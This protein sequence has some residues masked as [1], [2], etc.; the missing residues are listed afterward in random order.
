MIT[1]IWG[2]YYIDRWLDLC[3]AALRSEG[4]I[5]YMIEHCDFELAIVT[6][7]AD[8]E[9]MQASPKFNKIMAGIRIRFVP[10]DEF[11]P[12]QGTISYG[13]PLTL[14]YAKAILDL[15]DAA[16]GTYVILMNADLL[17]ASGSLKSMVAHMRAGDDIITG[18]S[19]RVIDG[20]PRTVL[21]AQIDRETGILSMG[22]RAMMRL[23][24]EHL[25]STVAGRVLNDDC[26]VDS[27]YYHQIYWRVSDDCLAMRAFLLHPLCFR[28]RRMVHTVFTPVDYGFIAEFCPDGRYSVLDD[29]DD[30]LMIELQER[31]SE[32]HWLRPAPNYVSLEHKLTRLGREI[33]AH[34]ASWTTAEH[35]RA[36]AHTLYY[37]AGDLP[38]TLKARV[39]RFDAFIDGILAAMPPAVSHVGHFQWLP[40][41]RVYREAMVDR[42]SDGALA[43]LD[44]PRN[45]A[46]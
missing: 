24:N 45:E 19:I 10:M 3:F 22:P 11:F 31:D 2:A 9:A 25:H 44:D 30:Y 15:G 4:N 27:T 8:I 14:A 5:P 37:H 17:L 39:R 28:I 38:R 18:S 33:E 16:I 36:A 42:G 43:L 26:P 1:P 7:T 23:A 32:A 12:R 29:T 13:V 6:M 35:R 41:V 20:R 46:A 21:E 34:A 40:A